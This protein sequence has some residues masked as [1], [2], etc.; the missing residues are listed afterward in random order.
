[1]ACPKKGK[2]KFKVGDK[3]RIQS[4]TSGHCISIGDIC[5]VS[6]VVGNGSYR[7]QE[8]A[9][10]NLVVGDLE[11]VPNTFTKDSVDKEKASLQVQMDALDAKLAFL[12]ETGQDE[13]CDKEFRVY[14]TLSLVEDAALTKQQKAKA[15]ASLLEDK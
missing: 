4:N 1:M 12:D 8:Y 11:F 15:I 13:G 5:T 3:V 14:Q 10:Y 9:N 6:M 2:Y 7:V